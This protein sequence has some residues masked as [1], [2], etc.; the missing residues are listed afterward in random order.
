MIRLFVDRDLEGKTR[1][2]LDKESVHYLA[3]VMRVKPSEIFVVADSAGVDNYCTLDGSMAVVSDRKP[4]NTEPS[5]RVTLLQSISKG[6]RMDLTIQKAVELGVDTIVP[7][8]STRCVVTP[9]E[10]RKCDRWR[11]IALEAARQSGRGRVP[12]VLDPMKYA[13]AVKYA[14]DNCPV[15]IFPWEEASGATLKTCLE[16]AKESG[17]TNIAV[18]IGPEGGFTP[19]EAALASD[20]GA[21]VVTLGPRILRTE[22]AGPAVLAMVLYELEL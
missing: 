18:F 6:E 20:A 2:E 19:E 9:K 7:V 13:E 8:F 15:M 1:V 12:E 11:K 10:N 14:K 3:D 17:K 16:S 21:S 4:N 22:T 5:Y